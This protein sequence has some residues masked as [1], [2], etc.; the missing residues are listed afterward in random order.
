M[1]TTWHRLSVGILVLSLLG[2]TSSANAASGTEGAAFL[3][4]P[5]GAGPAAMGS[6]YTALAD[7]AYASVWNPGALGF[8]DS[9]QLAG[10]QL[11]YLESI[12]NEYIGGAVPFAHNT[13]ALGFSA[14]YLGTGDIT[15]TN[16]SGAQIGTFGAHYGA[17]SLAYGQKLTDNL[18]LGVTGKW[19][20]A[21]L[22]DVSANAYAADL[23]L[24]YKPQE[25][26]RLA[27]T[28]TNLGSKLTFVDQSDS[29]PSAFHLAAAYQA[30][31]ALLVS[32]EALRSWPEDRFDGRVGLEWRPIDMIALRTGYRTDTTD[33]LSAIAGF[34]VGIGLNM[35]GQEFA[36]AWVPYGDLGNTQYFSLLMRFGD[37]DTLKQNMQKAEIYQSYQEK[38]LDKSSDV[39]YQQL[40]QLLSY[41]EQ[42]IAQSQDAGAAVR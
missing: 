24:L 16:T 38:D 23:G 10:Q 37:R 4:I 20:N 28:V 18:G 6:A 22:S 34:T 19:I 11:S 39:E 36:Y 27:A 12:N 17:Y 14:Q 2:I 29:L 1:I 5:V 33:Q 15:Q 25:R 40:M 9:V 42:K 8:V 35:W 21:Q 26:W 13:R 3:D 30:S 32:A 41:N 7:N 31:R